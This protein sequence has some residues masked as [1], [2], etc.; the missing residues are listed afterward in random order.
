MYVCKKM[1]LCNFLLKR[2]FQYERI[3]VDVF[4][5]KYNVWI[6]RNSPALQDA[7]TEYYSLLPKK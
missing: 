3:D 6:F 1:R 5:P 2:G 7:I 4:N